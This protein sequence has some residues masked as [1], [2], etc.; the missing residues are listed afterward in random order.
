[1]VVLPQPII[2]HINDFRFGNVNDGKN[3]FKRTVN[4]LDD[5]IYR[6]K[7][8][9]QHLHYLDINDDD[10]YID[11]FMTSML[12]KGNYQRRMNNLYTEANIRYDSD[13]ESS[14][15]SVDWSPFRNWW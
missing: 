2:D 7:V 15:S 3:L 8:V 6:F 10:E 5:D 4:E 9:Y 1:M 11:R 14:V 12:N 13:I